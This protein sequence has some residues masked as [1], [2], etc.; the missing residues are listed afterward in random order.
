[1]NS[2]FCIMTRV[3]NKNLGRIWN[4][5]GRAYV[6]IECAAAHVPLSKGTAAFKRLHCAVPQTRPGVCRRRCRCTRRSWRRWCCWRRA[7]RAAPRRRPRCCRPRRRAAP[8]TTSPTS[9]TSSGTLAS[10]CRSR[11]VMC[12]KKDFVIIPRH[13]ISFWLIKQERKRSSSRVWYCVLT[14]ISHSPRWNVA[15]SS[16]WE[17]RQRALPTAPAPTAAREPSAPA[18]S[19]TCRQETC[20]WRATPTWPRCT[21]CS[22]SSSTTP[23]SDLVRAPYNECS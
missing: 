15:T 7:R 22:T 5:S 13:S 21:S 11:W 23:R 18:A 17:N 16:A 20:S 14:I 3:W 2:V 10:A 1:M 6:V 4:D 9:S 19:A 12:Y 8:S